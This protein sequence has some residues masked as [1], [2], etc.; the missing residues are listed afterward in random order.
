MVHRAAEFVG[1]AESQEG[2]AGHVEKD[3]VKRQIK[4]NGNIAG[5]SFCG[6]WRWMPWAKQRYTEEELQD[7]KSFVENE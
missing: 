5:K 6:E 1:E 3:M 4:V 2:R 7:G